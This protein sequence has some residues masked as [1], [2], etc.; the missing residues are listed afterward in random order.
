MEKSSFTKKNN[1]LKR[2]PKGTRRVYKANGDFDCIELKPNQQQQNEIRRVEEPALE[3]L[4]NVKR[5]P[6]GYRKVI[7]KNDKTKNKCIPINND[8]VFKNEIKKNKYQKEKVN[9]YEVIQTRP[10]IPTDF[11]KK[12][13]LDSDLDS[14]LDSDLDLDLDL[15]SDLDLDEKGE[16]DLDEEKEEEEPIIR[17]REDPPLGEAEEQ[18]DMVDRIKQLEM[19]Y[20]QS[21]VP[22][23]TD[24]N[25]YPDILAKDFNKSLAERKEFAESVFDTNVYDVKKRA[26]QLCH[27][28]IDF[29]PYQIFVKNFLSTQTP[30]NGMLLYHGL[31]TGKTLTAVGVCEEMRQYMKSTGQI[32]PIYI[33]TSRNIRHNFQQELFREDLIP[34]NLSK[35]KWESLPVYMTEIMREIN[36]KM[37]FDIKKDQLMKAAH[38]IIKKYYKFMGYTKLGLEIYPLLNTGEK[39][40]VNDESKR[41]IRHR[42]SNTLMVIDEVHNIRHNANSTMNEKYEKKN[43]IGELLMMVA[44]YSENMRLLLMSA[45]PVF[46]SPTEIIRIANLLNV[47]DKRPLLKINDVFYTKDDEDNQFVDGDF[48]SSTQLGDT[49][50][51]EGG[52]EL[53][54]RKLQGYVS[55]VRG[56]NPYSFP[57]RIY[58]NMFAPE[59][60]FE[61]GHENWSFDGSVKYPENSFDASQ[62]TTDLPLKYTCLYIDTL[63]EYQTKIYRQNVEEIMDNQFSRINVTQSLNI[64]FP[65]EKMGEEGFKSCMSTKSKSNDQNTY[66]YKSGEAI[67]ARKN[68]RQYSAKIANILDIIDNSTGIVLIYSQYLV[69]GIISTALALEESGFNRY[70]SYNLLKP[71]H[72]EGGKNYI[73]ITGQ[74][75][76]SQLPELVRMASSEANKEGNI[77]KVILISEAG[78]EGI[79]FKNIRQVH[80]ME[81]WYNLNRMEQIIGRAVRYKSHCSLPFEQRNVEIYLHTAFTGDNT[82]TLDAYIYRMYAEPK[83][84]QI[85]RVN[86]LLKQNAVDL[87][88][89]LGQMNM[90]M[91][92]LQKLAENQHMAIKISSCVNNQQIEILDYPMGDKPFTSVCDY[93]KSCKYTSVKFPDSAIISST[94][95]SENQQM[96]RPILM[97]RIKGLFHEYK[98]LTR[99]EIFALINVGSRNYNIEEMYSVLTYLVTHPNELWMNRNLQWGYLTRQGDVFIFQPHGVKEELL[100]S[101]Q[102]LIS[103][104]PNKQS[105]LITSEPSEP[106]EP[107]E[108]KAS[109]KTDA[110]LDQWYAVKQFIE[111]EMNLYGEAF[112]ENKEEAEENGE[113]DDD[114]AFGENK[115][116]DEDDGD[117]AS[118][119]ENREDDEEN[120]KKKQ[121]ID[122]WYQALTKIYTDKKTGMKI[123]IMDLILSLKD[124]KNTFMKSILNHFIDT[125]DFQDRYTLLAMSLKDPKLHA[126]IAEYFRTFC[127]LPTGGKTY[128]ALY[129]LKNRKMHFF[130]WEAGE[131]YKETEMEDLQK[132]MKRVTTNPLFGSMDYNDYNK[133]YS[134]KLKEVNS[135]N[136]YNSGA[137]CSNKSKD[138]LLRMMTI[139]RFPVDLNENFRDFFSLSL[140]GEKCILIEILL[141]WYNEIDPQKRY[142]LSPEEFNR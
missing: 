59:H 26:E 139:L 119:G 19:E 57:F 109:S 95:Q 63:S 125:I 115:E 130:K 105:F 39:G 60:T 120:K 45:T 34:D 68:I 70:Q 51:M 24:S 78:S 88:L 55:Y 38:Q 81:P 128:Y 47:N 66:S 73:L 104:E 114:E 8:Q 103:R 62:K 46:D 21:L 37:V 43:K 98:Y 89:N 121:D 142:F 71:K 72:N 87:Y 9:A 129:D 48:R 56:E 33:I 90:T 2:C 49:I 112:G 118:A 29:H 101:V 23:S 131:L 108:I 64:V 15:D 122:S 7:D 75:P 74:T 30:Y 82:E 80:I 14:V 111:N 113:E 42:F 5:C 106:S 77:I 52:Q 96:S 67:F 25:L 135:K 31:G 116:D 36:P 127:F 4:E 32:K 1:G 69:S 40:E 123:K 41:K 58:P 54:A 28:P 84:I 137:F 10:K 6:K 107:S 102:R 20:N 79:D 3:Q 50:R 91:D 140:K 138:D 136:N 85:G 12:L 126:D 44:K 65:N 93:E 124:S 83:A 22:S 132:Q 35:I 13:D 17:V 16:E 141:R 100:S 61:L 97:Q 76:S 94:F 92:D 99:D 117:E 11:K 133:L 27:L 53:L 86:R 110:I 134:L 18:A